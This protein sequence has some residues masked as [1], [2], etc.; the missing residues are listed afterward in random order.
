MR[1]LG[2]FTSKIVISVVALL[3]IAIAIIFLGGACWIALKIWEAVFAF[4]A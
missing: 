1:L 4:F 2:A 3:T